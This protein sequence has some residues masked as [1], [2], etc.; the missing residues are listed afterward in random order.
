MKR[1]LRIVDGEAPAPTRHVIVGGA[2]VSIDDTGDGTGAA[3]LVE[4]LVGAG[5]SLIDTADDRRADFRI[6]VRGE[7][8]SRESRVHA[9]ALEREA[10]LVLGSARTAFAGY[11]ASACAGRATG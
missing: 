11:F 5:G 8:P 4:A 2:R 7:T 6:V 1:T 9:E 3:R 10:D